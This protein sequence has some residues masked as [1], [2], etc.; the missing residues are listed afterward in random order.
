LGRRQGVVWQ[1][2]KVLVQSSGGKLDEVLISGV[3]RRES[4]IDEFDEA[5]LEVHARRLRICC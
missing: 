5:M 1:E 2:G 4:G 3:G